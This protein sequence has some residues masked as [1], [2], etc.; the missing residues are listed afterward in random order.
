M[1]ARPLAG[2]CGGGLGGLCSCG[3]IPCFLESPAKC[4]L[5]REKLLLVAVEVG[6]PL[7][8]F[9]FSR[10]LLLGGQPLFLLSFGLLEKEGR[11][12]LGESLPFLCQGPESFLIVAPE[13]LRALLHVNS[14]LRDKRFP[15]SQLGLPGAV[16]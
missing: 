10:G 8:Q 14:R 5:A 9:A 2:F 11:A 7:H 4:F 12:L 13:L 16:E 15:G 3:S 6:L 1:I